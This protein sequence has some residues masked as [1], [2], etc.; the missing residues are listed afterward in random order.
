MGGEGE[1]EVVM[2]NMEYR[3]WIGVGLSGWVGCMNIER[4]ACG[5]CVFGLMSGG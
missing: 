5:G 1:G 4:Y 3:I 2:C